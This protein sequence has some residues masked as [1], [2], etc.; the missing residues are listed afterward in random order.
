MLE[1]ERHIEA[2]GLT[3]AEAAKLL[4]VTQP[5]IFVGHRALLSDMASDVSALTAAYAITRDH[6]RAPRQ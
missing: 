1:V 5:R 2:Q 4:H 3:Q 6:T